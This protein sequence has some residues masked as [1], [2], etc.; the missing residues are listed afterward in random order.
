MPS[1]NDLATLIS[2]ARK[3]TGLTQAQFGDRIGRPQSLVSKY[4]R[5]QVE[6]PGRVVMHCMNILNAAPRPEVS[7]QYVAALVETHLHE[8][9]FSKL[10]AILVDLIENASLVTGPS[11]E[12]R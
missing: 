4:E 12:R 7:S 10:R 11:K 6:P 8:P 3:L 1:S 5:G 2:S 9:T